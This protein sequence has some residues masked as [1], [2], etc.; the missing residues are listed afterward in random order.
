MKVY[1]LRSEI[2]IIKKGHRLY[3]YCDEICFKSKNLYNH[4]NYILRQAYT[5]GEEVPF[6]FQLNKKLKNED[7][8]RALPSKTS[9]QIIIKLGHNWKAFFKSIKDWSKSKSKYT[10]RP[11]IP[12]YK[13]KNGRNIVFFDYQQGTLKDGKYKFP[14]T[15]NYIE[16]NVT[17]E[18]FR[19]VQIIPYGSCYKICIVYRKK[20]KVNVETN[21]SYLAIDLGIDNLATLTNNIGEQPI[22]INGKIIKSV[23][24]YY[25][26]KL[27]KLR[28]YV[29]RNSS[30]RINRLNTKRNN[31]I[32]THFH[33]ISRWIIEYCKAYHIQNII[34][35]KNHDWQRN[36]KMNKKTNQKFIQ[37]PYEKFIH[38]LIYKGEE[39]GINVEEIEEQ[40]TSKSSFIDNDIIPTR[41]GDY[42]FSGK[43]I[44]RGI[45]KSKEDKL[46]NADVNG[47]Y[48]ILRKYL[49]KC[50]IQFSYEDVEGLSLNPIR[51]NIAPNKN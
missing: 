6:A 8:F 34:V 44:K 16:T 5:K 46:I 23:N 17:K 7:V 32:N 2:H 4:V 26:K 13:D 51:L 49:N 12:K 41:F 15:D 35:G 30:N 11:R 28:S 18:Q 50:N 47:S 39:L 40:Y 31:I 37:T 48:N 29:G 21:N 20:I 22:V 19:Q 24:Q 42:E 10:G 33:K 9:Q 36:S 3:S 45:Y 14:L 1:V 27:A 38:Q 25:N 43:R